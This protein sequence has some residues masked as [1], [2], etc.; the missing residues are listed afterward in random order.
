M[1]RASA[2]SEPA[3]R[4]SG[5][6]L[7]K[8]KQEDTPAPP[9][10]TPHAKKKRS[11]KREPESDPETEI[12]SQMET[13]AAA[14]RTPRR[15]TQ[16]Q[17][18]TR[19]KRVKV[20]EESPGPARAVA[21]E[22]KPSPGH[23]A[24]SSPIKSEDDDDLV[25][26]PR[27]KGKGPKPAPR[28]RDAKAADLQAKKL[29]SYA[30]FAHAS[31][32]PDFQHP[33]PSEC[34]RAHAVLA[35]LHGERR[36]PAQVVQ[37][38]ATRAGCGDSPSV[39]DALVRTILSQNTSDRNSSR[40]KR[41]M[42]AEYGGSDRWDAIV[43]GGAARLQETIASGGL[44][45]VKSRVI[46]GILEQ[47]QEKYGAYSLDHLFGASDAEAMEE[48]L[49]FKGVGPKTAS[50]VSLFCLQRESFAVD[51]HVH[52]ITGLLGWR[53][54]G[55]TRDQ[56]YAHLDVRIPDEEKYPL[57]VLIITHGKNCEECKAGGKSAGRCELRRAF[58]KGADLKE[59]DVEDKESRGEDDEDEV[60]GE[61]GVDEDEK[62]K[63]EVKGKK[64]RKIKKEEGGSGD[65]EM[66]GIGH[67]V[68]TAA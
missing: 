4:R 53:P 8:A 10:T 52:R 15:Q 45:V 33:T 58:R 55:C 20:E 7:G 18:R 41:A 51:T 40:A 5:R 28:S 62:V 26:S 2:P 22:V 39:L 31:P 46:I 56:A 61:D 21:P 23:D 17:T 27:K 9:L 50:C 11:L 67:A 25:D 44:S 66:G 13:D 29:K 57:H 1:A 68:E 16:T 54:R 65:E 43:A 64:T 14:A 59:D 47:V 60:K 63:V 49:A 6:N 34:R 12:A 42:D 19:N 32:F 3:R 36:R 38:S 37:A 35:R 24:A 48:M 30:Q